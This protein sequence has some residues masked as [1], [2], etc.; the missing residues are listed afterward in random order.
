[1]NKQYNIARV[2]NALVCLG[3]V[4]GIMLA[5]HTEWS[6]YGDY[7]TF[8]FIASLLVHG[9]LG[10]MIYFGVDWVLRR[11]FNQINE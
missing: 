6:K 9:G 10:V 4:I 1:M 3:I 5:A 2:I 7:G 8:Q 11:V